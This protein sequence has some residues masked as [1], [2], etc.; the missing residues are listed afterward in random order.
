MLHQASGRWKLGLVLA[1]VT[2]ACWATLPVALKMSLSVL[3][4]MTLTWFRFAFAA[5]FMLIWLG[6]RRQLS[7]YRSLH[8]RDW[9]WLLLATVLLIGNYVGYLLGVHYTT[10]GNAQLLIQ[11]APLLMA[12]GG[13]WV[14]KERYVWGQ[15]LGLAVIACGLA[16][17]FRDQ[18]HA[19]V[20]AGSAYVL[21][22]AIIGIAAVSWAAYAL[23]QKQLLMKLDSSHILTVLYVFSA[24]LLWPL[25]QPST[26]LRLDPLHWALLGYCA[27]NTLVAYGAF[28]EALAHW[29]ASR[30]SAILATTPLLC[31]LAVGLTHSLWPAA[32]AAEQVTALGIFGALL[33]V[34]GSA[35]SSLLGQNSK[36]P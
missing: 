32:I 18:L 7:P 15:W 31:L 23:I 2:A 3:D 25:A 24:I 10:P 29:Q 12:L 21:G 1:L 28:A 27:I 35:L 9:R 26:L 30:V 14:F 36:E 13:I 16:F 19:A 33:V 22:S 17:F 11:L 6:L 8:R 34:I 4:P 20:N 5:V